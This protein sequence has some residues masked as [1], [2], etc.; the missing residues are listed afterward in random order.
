MRSSAM[1]TRP[2]GGVPASDRQRAERA[3]PSSFQRTAGCACTLEL[4]IFLAVS[5]RLVCRI[6]PGVR[7]EFPVGGGNRVDT[8]LVAQPNEVQENVGDLIAC[9]RKR[10]GREA[11]ALLFGEPL[12]GLEQFAR[13]DRQRH[14]E[15]LG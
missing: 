3:S 14:R 8:Q 15:V 11:A 12:K 2:A 1:I 5:A 7:E 6:F 10:L 4:G 9:R 13:L